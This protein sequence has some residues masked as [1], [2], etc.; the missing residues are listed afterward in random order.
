MGVSV[1]VFDWYG[2]L[3]APNEDDV[4]ARLPGLVAASGGS[5]N[6]DAYLRSGNDHPLEHV[7]HSTD[8]QA[9]R[10]WQRDRLSAL[11]E[12]CEVSEPALTHL[13]DEVE[14]VR[15]TR[16]F[17]VFPDVHSTLPVLRDQGIVLGLCSNWDWDLERHLHDNEIAELFDFVI[18]SASLGYRK[19]HRSV[20]EKVIK[21]AGVGLDRIAFVGDNWHDD[22]EGAVNAGLRAVHLTRTRSCEQVN[23]D[24]A[25]C[26]VDLGQLQELLTW[27]SMA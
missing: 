12:R 8:E 7:E 13:L 4:W 11:L 22:V 1:V 23:H 15:Y 9:Y 5:P 21:T 17:S 20:F 27:E 2:T 25:E 18:C 6:A 3:A 26:V 24:G 19:P 10:R 14:Q 16:R